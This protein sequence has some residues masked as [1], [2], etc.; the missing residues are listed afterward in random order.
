MTNIHACLVHEEPDC[1]ADLVA[2]LRHFD[3]DSL[4]LL[5]DG[6]EG[7]RLT[8][9]GALV[10]GDGV[11]VHPDPR[12]MAW[13]RLHGFAFD[14]LRYAV[15]SLDFSSMTIVDSDQLLLR[16]GY[17][18]ALGD[19]LRRNRDIGCLVSSD[20]GTQ[21]RDTRSALASMAWRE[22]DL[23][24]P[25]LRRFA[26]G[27]Q[28]WP[29]WTFWPA[30]VL[31]REA[32]TDVVE[33]AGDPQLSAL[34]ARTR[35]WATE[36]LVV[37]TLVALR[38][39]RVARTPFCDDLVRFRVSWTVDHLTSSSQQ[40]DC[41]WVHP[42]PRRLDHPV[43]TVAAQPGRRLPRRGGDRRAAAPA[44][45]PGAGPAAAAGG[46]PGGP[47]HPGRRRP[48]GRGGAPGADRDTGAP[49]ARPGR[50]ALP[51]HRAGAGVRGPGGRAGDP[52]GRR[53]AR[54]PTTSRRRLLVLG[55]GPDFAAAAQAWSQVEARLRPGVAGG[56]PRLRAGAA[57]GHPTGRPPRGGR[58]AW[59]GSA[60]PTRWR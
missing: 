10:E 52:G 45:A 59:T 57:R 17:S 60:A 6:S 44:G 36:E 13:G 50:R 11:V 46:L 22:F 18:Q 29:T 51:T 39:H 32:A 19:H 55:D 25:F 16:S 2:N 5:Y 43:R 48:P 30:T 7:Q 14:S 58:V 34:L 8:R 47:D 37:P 38:G 4:V 21:P 40:T 12:P 23:W 42:V 15:E 3:P 41:F 53:R 49:R 31:T 1:V 27:E 9:M 20:G 33:L 54:P 24:R 56:V 28:S 26:R 35:L